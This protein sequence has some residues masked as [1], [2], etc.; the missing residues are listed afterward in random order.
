M[1]GTRGG[2]SGR[3]DD[4]DMG[5]V[6]QATSARLLAEHEPFVLRLCQQD[7]H[8]HDQDELI[9]VGRIGII[10]AH[11]AY[12]PKRSALLPAE[13]GAWIH[14]KVRRLLATAA[15]GQ[16]KQ[17]EREPLEFRDDVPYTNGIHNPELNQFRREMVQ[18]ALV[19]GAGLSPR[20]RTILS[21]RA[22][23]HTMEQI[24]TRLGLTRQRVNHEHKKALRLLNEWAESNSVW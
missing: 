7:Y 6:D 18:A 9:Q 21:A 22:R 14:W 24:G 3:D 13:E 10:Q 16:I 1:V 11:L 23:G 19:G 5:T 8:W 4:R 17:W 12:D 2:T 15:A 20:H